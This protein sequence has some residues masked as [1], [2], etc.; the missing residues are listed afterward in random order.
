M[1]LRITTHAI[2]EED[3]TTTWETGEED[4]IDPTTDRVGEEEDIQQPLIQYDS[5]FGAY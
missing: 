1:P 5:P 2:G 3:P 4:V